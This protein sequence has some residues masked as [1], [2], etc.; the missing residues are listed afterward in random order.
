MAG[1]PVVPGAGDPGLTLAPMR[2]SHRRGL[3]ALLGVAGVMVLGVIGAVVLLVTTNDDPTGGNLGSVTE[4][5]GNHLACRPV[6]T[7]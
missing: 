4:G 7:S 2:K 1:V 3:I 5:N 6:C